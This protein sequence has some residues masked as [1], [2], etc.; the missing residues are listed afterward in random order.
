MVEKHGNRWRYDFLKDGVRYKKGGYQT[1][2]EA[3][4]AEAEA[5]T[6]AKSINTDFLKLCN[7]RLEEI[8]IRRSK[9]HFQENKSFF[10]ELLLVWGS[11]PKI[12]HDDIQEYLNQVARKSKTLA[13]RKLKLLKA[14]FNHGIKN[15][16]FY[17]NPCTGIEKYGVD[18]TPKYIPPKEDIDKVLTVA[19]QEQR[20]YL[21]VIIHTLA[22]VRE[23]N[24]LKWEDINLDKRFLVLR[25]RKSKNS[26]LVERKIPI[27]DTLYRELD[28]APKNGEFVF[29]NKRTKKDFDYRDKLL[30]R[31]CE[32][33][34]VKP[35]T[36][37][38]LRHYGASKLAEL[39]VPLTDIQVL[40]GHQRATTT[41]IYLQSLKGSSIEAMKRL[42]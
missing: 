27:N 23:I 14:L 39:N 36:Y 35:F 7:S 32:Q 30:K 41:D 20:R 40:L 2:T 6:G 34:E 15:H 11:F 26:D 3:I 21:L 13:N 19:N 31:L 17:I 10:E 9:K 33:A 1:K 4:Q 25:T 29:I 24:R 22:R 37:H 18:K 12:N 5:R 16:W 8:E 38:C 28:T 42:E